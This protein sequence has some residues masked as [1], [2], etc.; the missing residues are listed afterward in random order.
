MEIRAQGTLAYLTT[1]PF[2]ERIMEEG[3]ENGTETVL[4]RSKNA[5]SDLSGSSVDAW[6]FKTLCQS[7][8]E[9]HRP[10]GD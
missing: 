7:L 10:K 6:R 9:R 5:K 3:F 2:D 1:D 4:V 8:S